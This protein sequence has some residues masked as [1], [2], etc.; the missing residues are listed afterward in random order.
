M[1]SETKEWLSTMSGSRT[2]DCARTGR[3]DV[4]DWVT[5]SKY[6]YKTKRDFN[7]DMWSSSD[8]C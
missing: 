5:R 8:L 1:G 6:R 7:L 3:T 4:G 2:A